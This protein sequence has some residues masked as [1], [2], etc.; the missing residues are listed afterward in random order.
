MVG[1][2]EVVGPARSDRMDPIDLFWG[3]TVRVLGGGGGG[4]PFLSSAIAP[5]TL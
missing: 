5:S 2:G 3:P 1:V 4:G